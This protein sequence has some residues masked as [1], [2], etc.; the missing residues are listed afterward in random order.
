MTDRPL[1]AD[2][3]GSPDAVLTRQLFLD[4]L[5]VAA[6]TK[7]GDVRSQPESGSR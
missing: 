7:V 6:G 3:L 1:A 5:E 2:R 4:G